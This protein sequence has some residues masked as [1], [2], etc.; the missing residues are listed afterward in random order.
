MAFR[1]LS[2]FLQVIY[3]GESELSPPNLVV[4]NSEP[5]HGYGPEHHQIPYV[6]GI[7]R[8]TDTQQRVLLVDPPRG[9]LDLGRQQAAFQFL[10][11]LLQ[12]FFPQ[13]YM[14][15]LH[16]L[17]LLQ[18]TFG[19]TYCSVI[20]A[21]LL[22]VLHIPVLYGSGKTQ[23]LGADCAQRSCNSF[24]A[25]NSMG[26]ERVSSSPAPDQCTQHQY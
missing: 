26:T 25:G 8:S 7:V 17:I 3:P 22:D 21:A 12:V 11:P 14:Q 2:V 1:E 15:M 16:Y 5:D 23:A 4:V 10:E 13:Q 18:L 24:A 9:L 6:E 20:D 19:I